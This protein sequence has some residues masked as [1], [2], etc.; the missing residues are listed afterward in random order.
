MAPSADKGP[1]LS[2][3]SLTIQSAVNVRGPPGW[4]RILA[5]GPGGKENLV[6]PE[7]FMVRVDW[8]LIHTL[9]SAG[10]YGELCMG[11]KVAMTKQSQSG[12]GD[13]LS[14]LESSGT[15][16]RSKSGVRFCSTEWPR[17]FSLVAD[18]GSSDVTCGEA[19]RA[20]WVVAIKDMI[21]R[22]NY[23]IIHRRIRGDSDPCAS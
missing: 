16:N 21:A 15:G 13:S 14:L 4:E 18:E 7:T 22:G 8:Q 1:N 10:G 2:A 9:R 12:E 20:R 17:Q 19:V 11:R 23:L 3:K 6:I 5:S